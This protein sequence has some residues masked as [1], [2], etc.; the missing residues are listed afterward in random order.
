MIFSLY[1]RNI[2]LPLLHYWGFFTNFLEFPNVGSVKFSFR[3]NRKEFV[4]IL[5][6]LSFFFK[7]FFLDQYVSFKLKGYSSLFF[8]I[9]VKK[10]NKDFYFFFILVSLLFNFLN[11]IVNLKKNITQVGKKKKSYVVMS[12]SKFFL[13]IHEVF[14][15]GFFYYPNND[16]MY[17]I[18]NLFQNIFYSTRSISLNLTVFLSFN[19]EQKFKG[20]NKKIIS[21][22]SFK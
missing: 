7:C 21:F 14:N 20:L 17:H 3:V 13:F 18:Y 19:V 4:F 9:E 22:Y 10:K 5:T 1:E 6:F 11:Q 15:I 8:E 16:F 12:T 2:I